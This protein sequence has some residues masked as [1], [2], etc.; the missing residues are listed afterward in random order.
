M[1][2][3]P[4]KA[5]YQVIDLPENFE[6][7]SVFEAFE[8]F[9]GI[10]LLDKD[11]ELARKAVNKGLPSVRLDDDFETAFFKLM[12]DLVEPE[13]A[14]KNAIVLYDYPASQAALAKVVDGCAKR[15]EVYLNGIELSN[16]FWELIDPKKRTD[17]A[18]KAV[19]KS[20]K[21]GKT[22]DHQRRS[23]FGSDG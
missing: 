21:T 16:A 6:K 11:P 20:G 13:L 15:F 1:P 2:P 17:F 3:R 10:P 7:I 14:K 4:L 9:V 18:L 22:R 23:I 8:K 5:G 19:N 12:L